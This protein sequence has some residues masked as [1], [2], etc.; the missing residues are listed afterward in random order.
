[1]GVNFYRITIMTETK[2]SISPTARI[3]PTA[4]IG[5]NC[6]I[7][8]NVLIHD[9]VDIGDNCIIENNVTIG[10]PTADYY[11]NDRY[12]NPTTKIGNGCILRTNS[13]IYAGVQ[14]SDRAETATNAVI[15]EYCQVGEQSSIGILTQVQRNTTIGKRV[16]I[17]GATHITAEVLIEDDVFIGAGVILVND[18]T[19]L[20]PIDAQKGKKT[21]LKAPIIRRGAKIGSNATI[22]PGVEIGENSIVGAAALVRKNVPSGKVVVG[23]SDLRILRDVPDDE[24]I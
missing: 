3:S 15:R 2:N 7:Q 5:Q 20:R 22:F 13:V 11:K 6:I 14:F 1:M 19:M 9:N 23:N 12:Q 4:K 17:R 8:D 24:K 10:H 21:I 18:N 16:N